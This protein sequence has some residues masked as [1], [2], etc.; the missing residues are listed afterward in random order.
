MSYV[1]VQVSDQKIR[2]SWREWHG[3]KTKVKYLVDNAS[4]ITM[5]SRFNHDW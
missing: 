3:N 5:T 1:L 4:M 2:Y